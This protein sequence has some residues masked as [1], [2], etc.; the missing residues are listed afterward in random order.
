MNGAGLDRAGV[1]E[2]F[3]VP[4]ELIRDFLT[5][6]GDK[7]DNVPGMTGIGDKSAQAV[8]NGIGDLDAIT[9]RLD[10]VAK[11]KFRGAGAFK[12]KFL[13]EQDQ[14]KLSRILVTIKTDVEL[15]VPLSVLAAPNVQDPAKVMEIF[16]ECDFKEAG[17]KAS[18]GD[19]EKSGAEKPAGDDT[20]PLGRS[21]NPAA[22]GKRNDP[23]AD[24]SAG[25]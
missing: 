21:G 7:V 10:E 19:K 6:K 25:T 11:L 23:Y 14:I 15:P 9:E 20:R 13:K 24:S 8:L 5:L 12:E 1:I 16:R 17:P 4:P 2:K 22:D 18:S 3:G